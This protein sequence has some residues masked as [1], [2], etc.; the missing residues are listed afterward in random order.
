MLFGSP[1]R[2]SKQ[3]NSRTPSTSPVTIFRTSGFS[4]ASGFSTRLNC[5][6]ARQAAR[7]RVSGAAPGTSA[8]TAGASGRSGPAGST[9]RSGQ[10]TSTVTA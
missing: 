9:P 7:I 3:P 8:V 6:P 2:K 4:P 5:E 1:C 10:L